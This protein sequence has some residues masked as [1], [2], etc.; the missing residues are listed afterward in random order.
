M[1]IHAMPLHDVKF[2]VWCGISATRIIG[3]TVFSEF[4][5]SH[6]DVTQ[7]MTPLFEYD[8]DYERTYSFYQ[9]DRASV[10]IE[11]NYVRS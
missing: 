4:V 1:L 7:N 3:P 10:N 8:F 2:G 11:N 9:Q 5:D 6:R